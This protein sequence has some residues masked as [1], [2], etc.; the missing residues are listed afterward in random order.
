MIK[1]LYMFSQ[2]LEPEDLKFASLA[3]PDSTSA[4]DDDLDSIFQKTY[5]AFF[6]VYISSLSK[7]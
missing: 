1:S 3:P 5:E 4:A 6:P 7:A 2:S